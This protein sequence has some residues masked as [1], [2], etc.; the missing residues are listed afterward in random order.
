MTAC[1]ALV[2]AAIDYAHRTF[3]DDGLSALI[4]EL[5]G[6]SRATFG[7]PREDVAQTAASSMPGLIP[8]S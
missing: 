3:D 4:H 1:Q 8:R 5:T 6:S 7:S 2:L